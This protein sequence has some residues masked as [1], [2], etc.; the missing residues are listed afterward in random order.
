MRLLLV[1]DDLMVGNSACQGL[2]RSEYTF[3][4]LPWTADAQAP[5]AR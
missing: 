4:W 2:E 1:E 3:D 5:A